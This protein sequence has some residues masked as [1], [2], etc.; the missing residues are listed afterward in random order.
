MKTCS[1]VLVSVFVLLGIMGFAQ[2]VDEIDANQW[3][4]IDEFLSPEALAAQLDKKLDP[5]TVASIEK[6][7]ENALEI[8][9]EQR[10]AEFG[11]PGFCV[12]SEK[13][14]DLY[15]NPPVFCH[16]QSKD[17]TCNRFG[18]ILRVE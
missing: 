9:Q 12:A 3:F 17:E 18:R 13:C 5:E 7:I 2:D 16:G 11:K 10:T 6:A 14:N 8:T 1:L 15:P 4:E